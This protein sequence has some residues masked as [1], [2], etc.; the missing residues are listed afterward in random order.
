MYRCYLRARFPYLKFCVYIEQRYLG[1]PY[2][3]P[4][5]FLR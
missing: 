4:I 1:R 2:T 3:A 5:P